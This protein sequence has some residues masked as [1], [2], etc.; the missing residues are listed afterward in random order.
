MFAD[1]HAVLIIGT[2]IVPALI[3]GF[4]HAWMPRPLRT[5]AAPT[6]V[7]VGVGTFSMLAL[8]YPG[9]P[10]AEWCFPL[11][12]MIVSGLFVK[13]PIAFGLL[14]RILPWIAVLLSVNHFVLLLRG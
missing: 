1:L 10:I 12:A 11:M 5:I 7:I 8:F 6:L 9:A 4:S 13:N 3:V 14:C 2:A